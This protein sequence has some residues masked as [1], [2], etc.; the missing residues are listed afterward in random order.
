[1]LLTVFMGFQLLF[2]INA[3]ADTTYYTMVGTKVNKRECRM[4]GNQIVNGQLFGSGKQCEREIPY[5]QRYCP[6]A[7]GNRD[8]CL[9]PCV[10]GAGPYRTGTRVNIRPITCPWGPL[11]GRRI[12]SVIIADVGPQH[13]DVF[14]GLCVKKKN[15]NCVQFA[16]DNTMASYGRGRGQEIQIAAALV[17]QYVPGA[18]N[19]MLASLTTPA[20]P[21]APTIL[22]TP[23]ARPI[24]GVVIVTGRPTPPPRPVLTQTASTLSSFAFD[25]PAATR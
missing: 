13:T 3:Y 24:P 14:T 6:W 1:M 5:T 2:A 23:P 7:I 9:V 19:T 20:G 8:N 22:P 11:K 25:F 15:D 12:T 21:P 16:P 10:H 4:E 17:N 18:G